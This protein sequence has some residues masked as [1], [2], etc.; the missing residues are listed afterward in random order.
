MEEEEEVERS[1]FE[2]KPVGKKQQFRVSM[3][4]HRLSC[5][6]EQSIS[7]RRCYV[8]LFL[9]PVIGDSEGSSLLG[10]WIQ[11]SVGHESSPYWPHNFTWVSFS[12][13]FTIPSSAN[14][15][16]EL[17]FFLAPA[18][19]GS[20]AS[21]LFYSCSFHI[22]CRAVPNSPWRPHTPHP[23]LHTWQT[24]E[25]S[26]TGKM[27]T[28]SAFSRIPRGPIHF[29]SLLLSLPKFRFLFSPLYFPCSALCQPP[30]S[31]QNYLSKTQILS[32]QILEWLHFVP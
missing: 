16:G 4:S 17:G 7:R 10:V 1:C 24:P 28:F 26:S 11:E 19:A 23:N 6:N 3:V 2:Q 15:L 29:S 5:S 20:S 12:L 14:W 32:C 18:A 27:I 21:L 22:C 9:L 13:I 31:P 30:H 8:Y 25:I